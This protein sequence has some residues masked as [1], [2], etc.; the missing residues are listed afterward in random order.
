MLIVEKVEN[1]ENIRKKIK[2]IYT[3]NLHDD[4]LFQPLFSFL[5]L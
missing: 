3:H 1:G 4:Q 2:I 5:L